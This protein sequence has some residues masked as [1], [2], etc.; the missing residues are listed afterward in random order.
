M[1][2][3]ACSSGAFC[4]KVIALRTTRNVGKILVFILVLSTAVPAIS[5]LT[6]KPV[7]A[8]SLP[9]PAVPE[10]T[11]RLVNNSYS[12][13]P[14]TT[15]TTDPYTGKQSTITTPSQYV[16]D[17]YI[18]VSIK[19]PAFK[20]YTVNYQDIDNRTVNLYFNVRSKGNY[21]DSWGAQAVQGST[22]FGQEMDYN[23]QYT[24][25]KLYTNNVPSPAKID[26][27]V[28][29]TIGFLVNQYDPEE[30]LPPSGFPPINFGINGTTSDWSNPQTLTIP[31]SSAVPTPAVPEFPAIFLLP[32]VILVSV[33]ISFT[34][35]KTRR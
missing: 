30:P 5:L 2:I 29:A 19:N 21:T 14:T 28:Q 7:N 12:T 11:V 35:R 32:F 3:L 18:E 15:T 33:T 4:C 25:V 27:E 31:T 9:T 8:Q 26:F 16:E 13:Q 22:V 10:F 1:P 20:Q 23:S 6:S 34:L 17:E 24:V